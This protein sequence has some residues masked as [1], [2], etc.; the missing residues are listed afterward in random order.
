MALS[1]TINPSMG[2][3][4]N[5]RSIYGVWLAADIPDALHQPILLRWEERRSRAIPAKS[6]GLY[7]E[8]FRTPF[9]YRRI[10]G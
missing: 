1:W 5:G 3:G 4:L 10:T 6:G 8:V 2:A 9:S 7:V